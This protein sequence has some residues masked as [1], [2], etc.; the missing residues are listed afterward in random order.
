[1]NSKKLNIVE[2]EDLNND[3]KIND[4]TYDDKLKKEKIFDIQKYKK[5]EKILKEKDKVMNVSEIINLKNNIESKKEIFV[6]I[7]MEELT[8]MNEVFKIIKKIKENSFSTNENKIKRKKRMLKKKRIFENKSLNKEKKINEVNIN[9]LIDNKN[10]DKN[11]SEQNYLFK[12]YNN[13]DGS[14]LI[15]QNNNFNL[16][17]LNNIIN[18]NQN[19]NI[20]S[21][22]S[23][24]QNNQ[25]IRNQILNLNNNNL[26]INKDINTTINNNNIDSSL[27]NPLYRI[28][29]PISN[30]NYNNYI[31]SYRNNN[32]L[33]QNYPLNI[34][35][36]DSSHNFPK[37]FGQFIYN[38]NNNNN[39]N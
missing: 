35:S 1:M 17:M 29:Y 3:I 13:L 4:I 5:I 11:I 32:E 2:K 8:R 33:I 37:Q 20:N 25:D 16:S 34:N 31:F 14:I 15:N 18:L 30:N 22:I 10:N 27:I 23:S 21:M 12:N 6:K 9:S 36:F 39:K 38:I 24:M 19:K 26:L 28:N 7:I